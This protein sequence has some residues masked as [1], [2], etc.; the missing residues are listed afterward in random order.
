[1]ARQRV[2]DP[3]AWP[4]VGPT[5]VQGPPMSA[6]LDPPAWWADALLTD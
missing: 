1:V 2:T 5:I 6:P 3:L 4:I